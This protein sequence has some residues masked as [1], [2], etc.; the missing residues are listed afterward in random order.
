[1]FTKSRYYFMLMRAHR[2]EVCEWILNCQTLSRSCIW[3]ISNQDALVLAFSLGELLDGCHFSGEL[4][5]GIQEYSNLSFPFSRLSTSAAVSLFFYICSVSVRNVSEST[6]S[7]FLKGFISSLAFLISFSFKFVSDTHP[8]WWDPSCL[9]SVSRSEVVFRSEALRGGP[10]AVTHHSSKHIYSDNNHSSR[11]EKLEFQ[12]AWRQICFL[13]KGIS[14]SPLHL[15]PAPMEAGWGFFGC[16]WETLS[17][18][19]VLTVL[20]GLFPAWLDAWTVS[21]LRSCGGTA[22][23]LW[24][25]PLDVWAPH[26]LWEAVANDT[27]SSFP[28]FVLEDS[29]LLT[30]HW[31]QAEERKNIS[32]CARWDR[33]S[34]NRPIAAA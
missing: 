29:F 5:L 9:V 31:G 21:A 6:L 24:T 34:L 20:L 15:Q 7:E 27:P 28:T 2:V 22:A 26:P 10:A 12:I 16:R 19:H 33:A 17:L 23:P 8:I 32:L 4:W 18:Q 25:A 30:A 11:L 14:Y 13:S 3:E 1:M